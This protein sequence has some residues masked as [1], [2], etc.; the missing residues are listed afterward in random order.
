MAEVA[1]TAAA[2]Q[3]NPQTPE[4]AA[5]AGTPNPE[6]GGK[7][8]PDQLQQIS[9]MVGRIVAN[10]MNEK[11]VPMVQSLG[12]KAPNPTA[13]TM[14]SN[15]QELNETLQNMIFEGK[16]TD[17]FQTYINLQSQ[18]TQSANTQKMTDIKRAL[19]GFAEDPNYRALYVDA[20][21]RALKLGAQGYP[22]GAAA[23]QAMAEAKAAYFEKAAGNKGGEGD[24]VKLGMS[25]GSGGKGTKSTKS[26]LPPQFRN[27][28]E[29]DIAAG[30][31]KDEADYIANLEPHIKAKYGIE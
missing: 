25:S 29:R 12:Q 14:P 7:F 2:A 28:A 3:N 8:T 15:L 24:D 17:A 5:G 23:S 16:V 4:P 1:D 13:P 6:T 31:F 9:S 19:T 21:A 26:K 22:A 18:A 10:Q 30:V 27:A 11:V 20:E